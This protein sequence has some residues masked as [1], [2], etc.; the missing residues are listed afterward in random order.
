M[1]ILQRLIHG[2]KYWHRCITQG[3]FWRCFH[4]CLHGNADKIESNQWV[5][6]GGVTTDWKSCHSSRIWS[7]TTSWSITWW[8]LVELKYLNNVC[9]WKVAENHSNH[10]KNQYA[11]GFCF[12]NDL[13]VNFI[14]N[15]KLSNPRNSI[16]QSQQTFKQNIC[17]WKFLF[18]P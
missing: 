15:Q 18:I 8:I 7:L 6:R 17:T 2:M 4:H 12:V 5:S 3:N 16:P 14:T 13:N 9:S 10:L 1:E 11:L